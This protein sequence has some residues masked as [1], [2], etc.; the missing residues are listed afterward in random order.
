[1]AL[2]LL[3][4]EKQRRKRIEKPS[5]SIEINYV[6]NVIHS[7]CDKIYSLR[8]EKTFSRRGEYIL[9]AMKKAF[10]H[11]E[12]T[13]HWIISRISLRFFLFRGLNDDLF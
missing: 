2:F 8:D 7:V 12:K 4:A 13:V 11:E 3:G 1:M 6:R 10:Q 5:V 9:I